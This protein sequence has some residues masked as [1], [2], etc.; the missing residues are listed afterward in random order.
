VCCAA[1]ER[2]DSGAN[3]AGDD[4][5]DSGDGGDGGGGGI[6][7]IHA[8]CE[9]MCASGDLQLCNVAAECP[10]G[11]ECRR[12]TNGLKS[13]RKPLADGG[14]DASLDAPADG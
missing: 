2:A 7:S 12:G 11:D 13:C 10:A 14:T 4:G 9:A 8:T 6:V 3:D 5:G 1:V